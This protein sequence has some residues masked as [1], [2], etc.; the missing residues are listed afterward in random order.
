MALTA[1]AAIGI[2]WAMT[3][4]GAPS[5]LLSTVF[6]A[7][8]VFLPPLVWWAALRA[9]DELRRFGL[10][11]ATAATLQLVG[12]VLWYVA[13]L[14]N[15]SRVPEPPGFWTPFLH[16][17][18]IF[19]VAGAWVG[20][21]KA[22]DLRQ[23][24]LDYSIVFAAASAVA[25]AAVGQRFETGLSAASLDAAVRPF[26]NVMMVT[27]V[28][29]ATLGRW[30]G[31]PL[32][33]GLFGVAQLFSASGDLLFGY[34]TAQNAYVDDRWTGLLWFTGAVIAM[35]AAATMICRVDRPI[36]GL[37]REPLP[38]VSPRAL[39]VAFAAAFAVAQS[40]TLYGA[41]ADHLAALLVGIAAVAWIAL[42]GALRI[43]GALEE[44][45]AAYRRLDQA[46]LALERAHDENQH[47]V[48]ERDQTIEDLAR[49]TVV[50]SALQT[51]F[52]SLLQLADERSDGDLRARLEETAED[53]AS[54]LPD[55]REA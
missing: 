2:Y 9:P 53:I 25:V 15:G 54:W 38:S 27:L 49:R 5:P 43:L 8:L 4:A 36:L 55:E 42:A 6:T 24:A 41:L 23:A 48:A 51:M 19:G 34:L 45:R 17:A 12:S 35:F 47:V 11:V 20:V 30:Q 46:H 40:V 31:L 18:L 3:L 39:F 7:T 21:R 16:L 52:G 32:P 10:L 22:L 29:S 37:A 44:L 28:G 50:L 1:G 26:F 14:K 33:V 13:F